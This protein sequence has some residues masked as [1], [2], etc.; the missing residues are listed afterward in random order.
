MN[1]SLHQYNPFKRM[2]F[3]FAFSPSLE[4]NLHEVVRLAE[5]FDSELILLHVG[6]KTKEKQKR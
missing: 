5:F 4:S 2:L 1:Q 3:G 6:E